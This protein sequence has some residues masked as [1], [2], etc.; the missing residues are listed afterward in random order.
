[1]MKFPTKKKKKNHR[2]IIC[3]CL[4]AFMVASFQQMPLM[5]NIPKQ[6]KAASITTTPAEE[7]DTSIIIVSNLIPMH[8]EISMTAAVLDS[9]F[10]FLEG[11]SPT[12]PVYITID[13]LVEPESRY[14][15][16]HNYVPNTEPNRVRLQQYIN[17]LRVHYLDKKNVHILPSVVWGHINY[18]IKKALDVVETKYVYVLQH[19][20]AF[21]RKVDHKAVVKTFDE[22]YPEHIFKLEFPLY[23]IK[24]AVWSKGECLGMKTPVDHVNGIN[25]TKVNGWSDQNHFTTKEYYLKILKDIGPVPRSPEFPMNNQ[26]QKNC[27]FLGVHNFGTLDGDPYI[28][29]LDGRFSKEHSK[30]EEA[31]AEGGVNLKAEAKADEEAK[32]MD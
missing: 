19:D 16:K 1:M 21:I 11:L 25:I 28:G 18:N 9:A 14:A 8:P 12:V 29:H 6:N 26:A 10:A 30:V 2:N 32:E 23:K 20:E 31:E 17:N 27:T 15:R 3:F 5:N 22:F 24:D 4:G 7:E 13:G